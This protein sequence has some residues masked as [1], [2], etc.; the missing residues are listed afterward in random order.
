[1]DLVYNGVG[2]P[3]YFPSAKEFAKHMKEIGEAIADDSE[4]MKFEI[5]NICSVK[6]SAEINPLEELTVIRYEIERRADPRVNVE[7]YAKL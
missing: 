6:I 1:M 7:W 2:R 4:Q 3:R 5:D